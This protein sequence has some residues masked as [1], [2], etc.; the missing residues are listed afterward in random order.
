MLRVPLW[1]QVLTGGSTT[2][3]PS[4]VWVL[5]GTG[6]ALCG[7]A[8]IRCH[9]AEVPCISV[10]H[11]FNVLAAPLQSGRPVGRVCRAPQKVSRGGAG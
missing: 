4:S 7:G 11:A 10:G 1:K 3:G 5:L 9:P 6:N 2:G 8:G